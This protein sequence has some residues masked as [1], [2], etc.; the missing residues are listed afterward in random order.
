MQVPKA[1]VTVEKKATYRKNATSQRTLTTSLAGIAIPW[2][3]SLVCCSLGPNFCSPGNR[4]PNHGLIV[5]VTAHCRVTTARLSAAIAT[6]V[7]LALRREMCT[8]LNVFI[9]GHTKVRCKEP[10]ADETIDLFSGGGA[11][12]NAGAEVG[13]SAPSGGDNWGTADAGA[14]DNWAPAP[15]AITAGGGGW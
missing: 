11:D 4:Y 9:V 10:P 13:T 5:K 8:F 1:V 3:I 15:A 14:S 6:R 7:S 2:D 12:D